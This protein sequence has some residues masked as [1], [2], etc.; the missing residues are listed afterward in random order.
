MLIC[1]FTEYIAPLAWS[2]PMDAGVRYNPRTRQA[3]TKKINHPLLTAYEEHMGHVAVI[4]M[5]KAGTHGP[6]KW[7][8][9]LSCGFTFEI[10]K[11]W[12]KRDREAALAGLIHHTSPPDLSNLVKAV[13]DGLNRVVWE[14]DRQVRRIVAE[15]DW[16]E[17]N[18]VEVTVHAVVDNVV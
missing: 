10:P 9:V 16:G 11:S 5:H 7:P 12:S 8:C 18:A 3:Y 17:R 1:K 14:D 13:E 2:R 4:A 6:V 15:K